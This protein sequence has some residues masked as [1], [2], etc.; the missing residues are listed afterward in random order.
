MSMRWEYLA[1]LHWRWD[2]A[3]I[4]ATLPEGLTVDTYDGAAWLGIVPFFMRRVH[5]ILCPSVPGIS[6]FLELN[7]RTYVVDERG[8]PGVWFYSLEC[9][10]PL[11]VE[12]ARR[13]FH[14][15]Y[16]HA[17]MSATRAGGVVDFHSRRSGEDRVASFRYASSPSG[18]CAEVGTIEFFLTERYVLFAA[19]GRGRLFAGRVW[20]E[21]YVLTELELREWSFANAVNDGFP[22]V[23]AGPDHVMGAMPVDVRAWP[24]TAIS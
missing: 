23:E 13:L 5:P 24:I 2:A 11:A 10:Q 15:N 8:V 7:V 1:F 22:L 6:D 20:H 9:N 19:N 21:P 3:Q 17:T 12:L 14:L 18:R 16:R 4:Q